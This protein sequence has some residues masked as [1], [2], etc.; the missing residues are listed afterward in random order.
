MRKQAFNIEDTA[1]I[2]LIIL[3]NWDTAIIIFDNT[4]QNIRIATM[5]FDANNILA[6]CHH[7]LSRL[8]SKTDNPL[9]HALLIFDLILVCQF[10]SLFQFIYT[11][12][13]VFLLY[14]FL[15]Q[16]PTFQK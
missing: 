16:N 11:Q 13:M 4:L 6:A 5:N 3:I 1:Y 15:S 14:N 2:V 7:F 10:Q 9:K 12:L 8:I